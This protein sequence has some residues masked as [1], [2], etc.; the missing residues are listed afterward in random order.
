[1]YASLRG[2]AYHSNACV[3]LC[4][5]SMGPKKLQRGGLLAI[6]TC[7]AVVL[8]ACFVCPCGL[9]LAA[10]MRIVVQRWCLLLCSNC[11]EAAMATMARKGRQE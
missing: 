1:M 6:W 8:H 10:G 4:V 11:T 7:V 3:G 2:K 9:E 5:V